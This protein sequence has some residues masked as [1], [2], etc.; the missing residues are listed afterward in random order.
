M[1]A[2]DNEAERIKSV[3]ERE[4]TQ[5]VLEN[6]GIHDPGDYKF[7][8][9]NPDVKANWI[10][11]LRSGRYEQGEGK[12]KLMHEDTSRSFYCCLG[13]LSEVQG[14]DAVPGLPREN[15]GELGFWDYRFKFTA[16]DVNSGDTYTEEQATMPTEDWL[17]QACD[18][19]LF[20]AELLAAMNDGG[21]SFEGIA[22]WI[23]ENL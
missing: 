11:A 15:E 20:E 6:H 12:L 18:M 22:N 1:E 17:N 19:G 16:K 8:K 21:V 23:E 4:V 13:I 7:K 9:M 10:E 14:L 2:T 3:L 5:E